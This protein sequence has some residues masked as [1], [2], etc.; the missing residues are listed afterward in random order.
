MT[1]QVSDSLF[2]SDKSTILKPS[3]IQTKALASVIF[4]F[5]FFVKKE[6]EALEL[7]DS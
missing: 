5:L 2:W 6:S 7:T 3:N 4:S 1:S